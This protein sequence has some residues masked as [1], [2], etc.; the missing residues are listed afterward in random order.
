[1]DSAYKDLTVDIMLSIQVDVNLIT[2]E[3]LDQMCKTHR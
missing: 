1:M 2:P 3:L